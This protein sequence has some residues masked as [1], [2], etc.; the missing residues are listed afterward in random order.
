MA[1][2]LDPRWRAGDMFTPWLP[3]QTPAFNAWMAINRTVA[4]RA[5][6]AATEWSSFLIGR[7]R[8]DLSLQQQ[9]AGC[10]TPEEMQHVWTHFGERAAAEYRREFERLGELANSMA[11]ELA[12]AMKAEPHN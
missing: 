12:Q 4:R 11:T 9:L 10:R 8:E 6:E 1:D 7:L 2:V 5:G 3:W